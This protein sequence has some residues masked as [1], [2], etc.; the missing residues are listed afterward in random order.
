MDAFSAIYQQQLTAMA[1]YDASKA[2]REAR[3]ARRAGDDLAQ[4]VDALILLNQA[5]VELISEKMK[6]GQDEIVA[7]AIEIDLR[8]GVRDGRITP[9][10][11][12]CGDC[13]RP[14]NSQ[15]DK[16]LYCGRE[17]PPEDAVSKI[18]P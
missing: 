9:S 10:A 7:R 17:R 18:I 3:E 13:G 15:Q 12:K 8:D 1:Q 14:I 4:K 11:R 2:V 5:M 16:C 6:I